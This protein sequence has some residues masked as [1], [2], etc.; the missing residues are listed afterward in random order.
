MSPVELGGLVT[1][2]GVRLDGGDAVSDGPLPGAEV[3]GL[4]L[5]S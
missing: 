4:V 3:R 2:E 1:D 5:E